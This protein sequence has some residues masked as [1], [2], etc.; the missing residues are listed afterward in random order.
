MHDILGV[1]PAISQFAD[2]SDQPPQKKLKV[3]IRHVSA[4]ESPADLIFNAPHRRNHSSLIDHSKPAPE[5]ATG[6]LSAAKHIF[7]PTKV[8]APTEI[9]VLSPTPSPEPCVPRYSQSL[10]SSSS[11]SDTAFT[12]PLGEGG[13]WIDEESGGSTKEENG[14]EED[15]EEELDEWGIPPSAQRQTRR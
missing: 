4:Y 13:R 7:Q 9:L 1:S 5:K 10:P 11:S 3:T 15:E 6:L 14:A 8:F 12:P 2:D